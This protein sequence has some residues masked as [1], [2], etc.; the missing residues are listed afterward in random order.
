MISQEDRRKDALEAF[1]VSQGC[2]EVKARPE[3]RT[4]QGFTFSM[5]GT[6]WWAKAYAP[7]YSA[8]LATVLGRLSAGG[9]E[10]SSDWTA[11]LSAAPARDDVFRTF[12]AIDDNGGAR[13]LEPHGWYFPVSIEREAEVLG[14]RLD[15]A[16]AAERLALAAALVRHVGQLLRQGVTVTDLTLDNVGRY[17]SEQSTRANAGGRVAVVDS[18]ALWP[19]DRIRWVKNLS[20]LD[21]GTKKP[22]YAVPEEHVTGSVEPEPLQV[23]LLG[24]V[25][26]QWLFGDERFLVRWGARLRESHRNGRA[27]EHEKLVTA[28]IENRS[29]AAEAGWQAPALAAVKKAVGTCL[30]FSPAG[31]P[32]LESL[33]QTLN[34]IAA[35]LR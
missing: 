35:S 18:A 9:L 22:E 17:P 13:A 11:V 31:R 20:R 3:T 34:R 26:A 23:Y 2:E 25:L 5:N 4:C 16:P 8:A 15:S 27:H 7:G 12:L 29:K 6:R 14:V 28:E 1:L 33:E 21:L 32:S 24:I 19:T 10:T 30:G